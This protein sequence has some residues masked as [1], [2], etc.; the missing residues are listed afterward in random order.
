MTVGKT[1]DY[2]K[3]GDSWRDSRGRRAGN[4]MTRALSTPITL[5]LMTTM[6]N[7]PRVSREGG[8]KRDSMI[9]KLVTTWNGNGPAVAVKPLLRRRG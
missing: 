5:H 6:N 3:D 8:R 7:T 9:D 1:T 2:R 4:P